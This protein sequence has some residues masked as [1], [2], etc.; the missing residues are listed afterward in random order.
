V[1]VFTLLV[2][3]RNG[4]LLTLHL[5]AVPFNVFDHQVFLSQFFVVGEVINNL[6]FVKPGARGWV[7]APLLGVVRECP[8]QIEVVFSVRF[9]PSALLS[10]LVDGGAV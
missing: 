5:L 1:D 8:V 10:I 9:G 7:E 3:V 4:L 2:L 6:K